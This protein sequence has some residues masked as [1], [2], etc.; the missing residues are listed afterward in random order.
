ML[1]KMQEDKEYKNGIGYVKEIIFDFDKG[2]EYS[3]WYDS[4][5]QA[6]VKIDKGEAAF[7][8]HAEAAEALWVW[9]MKQHQEQEAGD[10]DE[11][12]EIVNSL[13][14]ELA[15]ATAMMNDALDQAS[16]WQGQEAKHKEACDLLRDWMK[17]SNS[18]DLDV[19]LRETAEFLGLD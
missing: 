3:F 18:I 2:W 16:D 5:G 11:K 12:T 4:K 1:I 8:Y 6:A 10:S 9:I 15:R 14:S 7:Y 17:F 19:V 13:Q